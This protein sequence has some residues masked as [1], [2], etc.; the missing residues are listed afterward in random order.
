MFQCTLEISTQI[1]VLPGDILG[2]ELPPTNDDSFELYFTGGGPINYI[3]N[4]QLS[5]SVELATG[6]AANE[7]PQI[8]LDVIS[9]KTCN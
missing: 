9:G 7:E 1:S 2:V 5:S 3:F 6:M 4:W 8:T